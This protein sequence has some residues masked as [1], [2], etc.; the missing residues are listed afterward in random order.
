SRAGR[1]VELVGGVGVCTAR[2]ACWLLRT[3]TSRVDVVDLAIEVGGF[4]GRRRRVRGECGV[5]ADRAAQDEEG[6]QEEERSAFS[7]SWHRGRTMGRKGAASVI[8]I[9]WAERNRAGGRGALSEFIATLGVWWQRRRRFGGFGRRLC[10]TYPG[11]Y[12]AR[13]SRSR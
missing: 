11:A 1:N 8:E 6:G 3:G 4:E 13:G 9:L 5:G 12:G 10:R 2:F 7:G